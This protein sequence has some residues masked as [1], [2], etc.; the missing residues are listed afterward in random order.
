[1]F[2]CPNEP[3]MECRLCLLDIPLKREVHSDL[4]AIQTHVHSDLGGSLWNSTL[5]RRAPQ[6]SKLMQ[7]D[8]AL[9]ILRISAR[10]EVSGLAD[11]CIKQLKTEAAGHV[12]KMTSCT[13]ASMVN[14]NISDEDP[15]SASPRL[16]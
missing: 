13:D 14:S 1:M 5:L 2:A 11:F 3:C 12:R 6:H 15:E 10:I 9:K 8:A 7:R 16:A 4:R